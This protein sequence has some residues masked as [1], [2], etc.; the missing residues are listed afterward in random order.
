[1]YIFYKYL[2]NVYLKSGKDI[3][4]SEI[5]KWE[6]IQLDNWMEKDEINN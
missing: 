3:I 2:R 4:D 1:M 5:Y 6:K